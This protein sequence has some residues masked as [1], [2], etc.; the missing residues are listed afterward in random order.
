MRTPRLVASATALLV[1][2][3]VQTARADEWGG[4][5]GQVVYAGAVPAPKAIKADKDQSHCLSKGTLYD[6]E[7]VVDDKTKG[8]K[9]VMVWLAPIQ[10]GS[11]FP[12]HPDLVA[13]PKETVVID[14]PCCKFEPRITL[15]REGQT[16]EIKNSAPV[17]HNAKL[18]GS[19]AV[20]GTIN[21]TIPPGKSISKQPLAEKR[22]MTIACDIHKWM[23]GRVAV[24]NHPY[25]ALTKDDGTFEIKNAPAGKFK[26]FLLHEKLNWVHK[27]KKAAGEEIEIKAGGTVDLG[28][29]EAK[30]E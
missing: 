28:R 7:L 23:G 27:G 9:N 13:V 12:V 20:N 3:C 2:A 8:V 24:F 17:L 19:A 18:V 14:Q 11:K 6:D 29:Y 30:D 22:P 16:L 1:L 25:F 15:M 21:L 10:S 26:L 5:K 4:I